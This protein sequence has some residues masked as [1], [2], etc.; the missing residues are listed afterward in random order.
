V[1]PLPNTGLQPTAAPAIMSAAAETAG[2][3]DEMID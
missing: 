1:N 3:A 2:W